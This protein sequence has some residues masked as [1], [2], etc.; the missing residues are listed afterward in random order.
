MVADIKTNTQN[1]IGTEGYRYGF[2]MPENYVFKSRKGLDESVVREISY[3]KGEPEWMTRFRV[4]ALK[5]FEGKPMPQWGGWLNDID[6][7]DIYYYVRATDRS[8]TSW[9][10]V[11]EEVKN[12]FD[13][14][15]IGRIQALVVGE[16]PEQI[17]EL[18]EPV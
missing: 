8:Q 2:A 5:L 15:G 12:T 7:S 13:R 9:D 3:I 6:F 1:E 17:D 10:E 16:R 14:L 11:P 4:R 18:V